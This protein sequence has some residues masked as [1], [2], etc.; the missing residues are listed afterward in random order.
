M[1]EFRLLGPVQ[2]WAGM[3]RL[4]AGL[5]RQRTVRR[6]RSLRHDHYAGHRDGS[7][8]RSASNPAHAS[9]RSS[10]SKYFD[11]CWSIA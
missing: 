10:S 1:G 7:G 11:T 3:R 6:R 8:N 4:A 5:H 2:V 9:A